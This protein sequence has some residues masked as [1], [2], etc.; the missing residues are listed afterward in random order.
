[1]IVDET[2]AVRTGTAAL[3]AGKGAINLPNYIARPIVIDSG[4]F[5]FSYD[6]VLKTISLKDSSIVIGG[7]R[8]ALEG[9]FEPMR[10]ADGKMTALKF[11]VDSNNPP[12]AA[13]QEKLVERISFRG[14]TSIEEQRLDIEDLVVMNGETG[15]RLRGILSG[16][17]KSAGIQLAGRLRDVNADLLKQLWPPIVTPN[18]RTWVNENVIGGRVSEGT[19][20][21]NL[22]PDALATALRDKQF[23]PNSISLSIKLADIE[24]RYFHGLSPIKNGFGEAQLVNDDFHLVINK[25]QALLDGEVVEVVHGEFDAPDTLLPESPGRVNFELTTT[26]A[27]LKQYLAQPDLTDIGVKTDALPALSGS[28]GAQIKLDFPLIKHVPKERV[29]FSAGLKIS[30]AAM[31]EV[32]PGIDL[33]NGVF[34]VAV[35]AKSIKAKGTAQ[36]NKLPATISWEKSRDSGETATTLETTLDTATQA[37]LGM[38][39]GDFMKGDVPVKLSAKGDV[40]SNAVIEADLS[41]VAMSVDALGW[42]RGATKGTKLSLRIKPTDAGKL[43]D[44]LHIEGPGVLVD[45]SVELSKGGSL[46]SANLTDVR[47]GEDYAFAARIAP[48]DGITKIVVKGNAFD[49]RPYIKAVI[50]PV[51]GG[52]GASSLSGPAYAID[53]S[54]DRVTAN[55]GE[56]ITNVNAQLQT[57]Q[58]RV[59][60]ASISGTYLSG[61]PVKLELS[62]VTGGRDLRVFS[63]DGGATLRAA[64]FY[65]KVAGGQLEFSARMLNAAGSPIRDGRLVLRQFAVRNEAA[66]AELDRRGKPQRSGPRRDGL[67]FKRF[68]LDFSSD[69]QSVELRNI[70]LK[71]N[72]LGA[73]AQGRV[74]KA[75]GGLAIGGTIIPAQAINGALDDIPLLGILLSGGNNE[76]VIGLTFC[77]GG[78]IASPRWQINPLSAILP[79]ILRKITECQLP[80]QKK[81]EVT[82][83]ESAAASPY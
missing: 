76:G 10:D 26:A 15:V 4:N 3:I 68:S 28:V 63:T 38:N 59:Q 2:G 35:D 67:N 50:S 40:A 12:D 79:G 8:A 31:H 44:G 33:S 7:A 75:N 52:G 78:T 6:Q 34:D 82:T 47:L 16:G 81:S 64:N 46:R 17:E 53:A 48:G 58:S 11:A 54:F 49:A 61:L 1:L 30:E 14:Q 45:G 62:P 36:L 24:S 56:V 70:E 32:A 21:I 60:S 55:R 51:S 19:F 5:N 66:L 72:D 9:T 37:R 13:Q 74:Y 80:R 42:K 57:G 20:Q 83:D 29:V 65:S 22:P 73:V 25:G 71:G 43:L 77:M 27:G 69:A 23:Q 18:T 39:L 41:G